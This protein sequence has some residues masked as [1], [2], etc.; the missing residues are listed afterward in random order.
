[1]RFSVAS[2]TRGVADSLGWPTRFG[3]TLTKWNLSLGGGRG[4]MRRYEIE[5]FPSSVVVER[6]NEEKG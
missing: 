4:S 6:W 1:M 3:T 5:R 2:K